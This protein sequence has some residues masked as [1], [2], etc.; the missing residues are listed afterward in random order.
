M[1]KNEF[2]AVDVNEYARDGSKDLE[3]NKMAISCQFKASPLFQVIALISSGW[4][5]IELPKIYNTIWHLGSRNSDIIIPSEIVTAI[6]FAAA[7]C[8]LF[9]L[10]VTYFADWKIKTQGEHVT[11]RYGV[12]PQNYVFQ[13]GQIRITKYISDS[14]LSHWLGFEEIIQI[15]HPDKNISFTRIMLSKKDFDELKT[16]F[17]I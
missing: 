11:I 17:Q 10:Y 14:R 5:I 16:F 1:E 4:L 9:P 3:G 15:E 7:V 8:A 12:I 6:I 13:L 2:Q